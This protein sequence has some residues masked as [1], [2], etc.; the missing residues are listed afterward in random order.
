MPPRPPA[1]TDEHN[2]LL[3][4]VLEIKESLGGISSDLRQ[5]KDEQSKTTKL[6]ESL[7]SRVDQVVQVASTL[8]KHIQDTKEMEGRLGGRLDKLEGDVRGIQMTELP[9]IREQL[10]LTKWFGSTRNKIIGLF[11]VAALGAIGNAAAGYFRDNVRVSLKAPAPTTMLPQEIIAP[12]P[13]PDS[14]VSTPDI[15]DAP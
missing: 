3:S 5:V 6:Y 13:L 2:V 14:M 8:P 4:T 9:T 10:V 1:T 11:F 12:M 15:T 7:E